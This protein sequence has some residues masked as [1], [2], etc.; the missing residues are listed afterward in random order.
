MT[1]IKQLHSPWVAGVLLIITSLTAIILCNTS[2]APH[3]SHIIHASLAGFTVEKFVNDVLMSV[4]F[5]LVGLEIK[6]EF[7]SGQLASWGQRILPGAAALGGMAIP[8]LVYLIFNHHPAEFA[9]GWAIPSATDIAFSLGILSLL[10]NHVPASL[11]VFLAA[12]AIIDD[13][14]AV[15]IIA[16]FYTEKIHGLMLIFAMI[17]LLI[18]II[19]NRLKINALTPYLIVGLLLWFFVYG[20]GVH[21]TLAGV[22][23][24]LCLPQANSRQSP[25]VKLEAKLTPWVNLLI[26]PVFGFVN[27]GV[28]LL[29]ISVDRVFGALPLGIALGLFVGKQL[30]ISLIS[31][32]LIKL[33]IARLPTGVN[34]LQFY[35]VAVLCGVGFTM[36][37][38]IGGLAFPGEILLQDEVKIGVLGGSLLSASV[39]TL[40]LYFAHRKS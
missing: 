18:L 26:I 16:F 8:A 14:G 13:L 6:R 31:A 34:A 38:F 21:V 17:A 10:G 20:S 15:L 29:P 22:L 3:Y 40:I 11:K 9:R 4:F 33:G 19:L 7:L 23:L 24:A 2:A 27:A 12:L 30:G 39:G 5:L 37:L 35:G 32:I 25:S 1:S 36:S 28:S